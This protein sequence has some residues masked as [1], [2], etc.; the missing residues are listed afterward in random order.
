[1]TNA[2]LQR[3]L[4]KPTQ[5]A[6]EARAIYIATGAFI[7][8]LIVALIAFWPNNQHLFGGKSIGLI[9]SIVATS[10]SL[11]AFFIGNVGQYPL[12]PKLTVVARVRNAFTK[13]A[14][15]F[16]H[17]AIVFLMT[18]AGYFIFSDAFKGLWLDPMISSFLVAST[19][20]IATYIV[21]LAA[22]QITTLR[23]STVLA[24]F[25][26]TGVITSMITTENPYWWQLHF[27]SLGADNTRSSTAFNL[28]LIIAGL[29]AVALSDFIASDFRHLKKAD[30]RYQKDR[31][32]I[33]RVAIAVMG[34]CLAFVGIFVYNV[35]PALHVG[36]A[37]GMAFIFMGMAAFS[38][39]L[40]PS[41]SRAFI[42]MTYGFLAALV[43]SIWLYVGI[44]Y[45]TLTAFELMAFG[46]IFTWLVVFIRQIAAGLES[47]NSQKPARA[48]RTKS[49]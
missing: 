15:A 22:V 7:L 20:S 11:I 42:G 29:V 16:T 43:V 13:T 40:M 12:D 3:A 17:A 21:Y 1:M 36:S 24:I 28:T 45:F 33:I 47:V 37:V 30:D 4:S 27:S 48:R 26:A 34:V 46:V 6:A 18:T 19:V 9:A 2:H 35:H 31:A 14:L 8:G 5:H 32:N 44:G 25:L 10:C 38:P 39:L 41:F 49:V 23:V